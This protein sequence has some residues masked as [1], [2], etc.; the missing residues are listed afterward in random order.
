MRHP[1][2]HHGTRRRSPGVSPTAFLARPP[3]V[4]PWPLM[5]M[6]FATSCPLVRPWLPR[7]RFLFVGP[8]FCSTL[9]SNS[10]SRFCPCASLVFHLHQVTQGT[11]TPKL[12][13]M[14]ST[15]TASRRLRRWPLASLDRRSAR[16][17]EIMQAGAEKRHSNR[18]KKLPILWASRSASGKSMQVGTITKRTDRPSRTKAWMYLCGGDRHAMLGVE[19]LSPFQQDAGNAEHPVSDAA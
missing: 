2:S 5:D 12:L 14:P 18:T 6:D 16:R 3:D 10:P 8:R 11:F 7:I 4:Q 17:G 15:Q 1:Q 13:D 9:P 19:Q